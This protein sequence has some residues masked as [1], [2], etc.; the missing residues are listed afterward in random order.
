MSL[1]SPPSTKS[2]AVKV[3]PNEKVSLPASPLA[4][5]LPPWVRSKVSASAVPVRVSSPAVP[6]IGIAISIAGWGHIL[7]PDAAGVVAFTGFG[8]RL[9]FFYRGQGQRDTKGCDRPRPER[10]RLR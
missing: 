8:R 6:R 2:A 5:S 7:T 1:P 4:L 10:K 3:A 9:S